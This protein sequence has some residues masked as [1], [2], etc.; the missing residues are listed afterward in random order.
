MW[1]YIPMPRPT[2]GVL[3]RFKPEELARID[4]VRGQEPRT[5]FVRRYLAAVCKRLEAEPEEAA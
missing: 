5:E 1:I 2:H 3:V 4:A